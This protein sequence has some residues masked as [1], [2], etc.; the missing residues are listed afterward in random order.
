MVTLATVTEFANKVAARYQPERIV[1]F[2]SLAKRDDG[3]A[4]DADILVILNH[5]GRNVEKAIEIENELDPRFPLDLLVR[6][7]EQVKQRTAMND[8][9]IRDIVERGVTLYDRD[10]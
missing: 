1:L 9:F 10:R 6:T 3:T 5:P 2:G 7:P 8:L 4:N